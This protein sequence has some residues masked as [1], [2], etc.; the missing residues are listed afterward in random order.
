MELSELVNDHDCVD[1]VEQ[2]FLNLSQVYYLSYLKYLQAAGEEDFDGLMQK[3]AEKVAAG[4]TGFR[5]KLRSSDLKSI[6]YVLIDEYQDFSELFH[7]LMQALKAQNPGSRFFCVGDDWPAIN[8]FAGSDLRFFNDF[9][10]LFADSRRLYMPTNYRS[11]RSIVAT[12]NALMKNR[13]VPGKAHKSARGKAVIADVADFSPTPQEKN[14]DLGA[15][16]TYAVLRLVRKIIDD[17]KKVAI[18]S[19]TNNAPWYVN[20]GNQVKSSDKSGLDRF[21]TALRSRLPTKQKDKIT[22]STVHRYKGREE[23]AVIVLDA[24]NSRYPLLH[25]NWFFT[26]VF[27]DSIEGITDEERRL[28]YVALTR[29][30]KELYILTEKDSPSPFL[31]DLKEHMEL[32]RLDWS[33]YPPVEGTSS[34][35]TSMQSRRTWSKTNP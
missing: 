21:L 19:R 17:G 16:S 8:G 20:H 30:K 10:E 31:E 13:G 22:I 11:A 1:D 18:L 33:D 35:H 3:A 34:Y 5:R 15:D 12:G 14:I 7:G 4:N 23:V 2:R 9:S 29:A 6:Q 28:F 26:R 27:G 32:S 24:I 25:P